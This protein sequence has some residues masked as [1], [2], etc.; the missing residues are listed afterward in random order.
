MNI[1]GN[2]ELSSILQGRKETETQEGLSEFGL[3]EQLFHEEFENKHLGGRKSCSLDG[4]QDNKR[5][6]KVSDGANPQ[7]S[8]QGVS[9]YLGMCPCLGG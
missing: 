6:Q 3:L 4:A 1:A 7:E 2:T 5:F 9:W 8:S